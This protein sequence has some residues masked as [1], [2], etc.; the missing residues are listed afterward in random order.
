MKGELAFSLPLLAGSWVAQ[1][2]PT[3]GP[4]ALLASPVEVDST[5]AARPAGVFGYPDG[6]A[7]AS[8]GTV[9]V[10]DTDNTSIKKVTSAGAVSTVAASG[11]AYPTGI[12]VASVATARPAVRK[13]ASMIDILRPADR[14]WSPDTIRRPTGS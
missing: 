3:A 2:L 5:R 13:R 4:A 9:Y 7:V 10:V 6:V 12:A 11:F 14:A 8:D 1:P